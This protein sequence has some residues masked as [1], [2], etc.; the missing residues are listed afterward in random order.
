[1]QIHPLPHVPQNDGRQVERMTRTPAART[2]AHKSRLMTLHL[3]VVET[4]HGRLTPEELRSEAFRQSRDVFV[5]QMWQW[6][7]QDAA[8]RSRRESE[9]VK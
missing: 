8:V 7:P 1:M 5:K 4:I 2:T 3:K 9:G 6:L